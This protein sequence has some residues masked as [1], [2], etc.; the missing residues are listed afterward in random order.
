MN[1]FL[2]MARRIS[3]S[4]LVI[5]GPLID[6]MKNENAFNINF[7]ALQNK[8]SSLL[9]SFLELGE[10]ISKLSN[11]NKIL[12]NGVEK[13]YLAIVE[14]I[15]TTDEIYKL[16]ANAMKLDRSWK[17]SMNKYIDLYRKALEK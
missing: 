14:G 1:G 13:Q 9:T 4:K 16:I 11:K 7:N 12:I 10:E 15:L 5:Y 3:P 6:E 8:Y 2:E 17:T